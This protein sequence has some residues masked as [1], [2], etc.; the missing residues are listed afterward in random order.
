MWSKNYAQNFVDV[1][2]FQFRFIFHCNFDVFWY[3]DNDFFSSLVVPGMFFFFIVLCESKTMH[4]TIIDVIFFRHLTTIFLIAWLNSVIFFFFMNCVKQKC[5][6]FRRF[7]FF[8]SFNYFSVKYC[9]LIDTLDNGFFSRLA[10]PGIFVFLIVMVV[11][12]IKNMLRTPSVW[13]F[14][15]FNLF[16]NAILVIFDVIWYLD[17]GFFG[18]LAVPGI[19]FF[20][21]V[22]V[23]RK[24]MHRTSSIWFFF[25]FRII[26]H[27]NFDVFWYLDNDFFSSLAEPGIFLFFIV[28]VWSKNMHRTVR[29]D[30]FSIFDNDFFSSLVEPGIFFFFIVLCESKICTELRRC[31]LF[32]ISIYFSSQFWWL[33]IFD[34]DFLRFGWTWHLF[35]LY[36]IVWIKNLTTIFLQFWCSLVELGIF[37]FFIVIVW[38]KNCAQNFVDMIFFRYLTIFLEFI[39]HCKNF[40]SMFFFNFDLFFIAMMTI[41]DNDFLSSLA[42]PGIFLF[43]IVLCESK[44]C[45][46]LRRCF[47]FNFDLFFIAIL[48]SF[49]I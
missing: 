21:I 20:F 45:S 32:S 14:F 19:F 9:W 1:I 15:Y 31:D 7:E 3:L 40:S 37:F 42:E 2:F 28:I 48:M 22:I 10:E 13:F 36:R 8:F 11:K 49:D 46:E 27:C 23:W 6:E 41:F 38:S 39:F 44:T 30:L 4:R 33:L 34:N 43:F 18:S 16:L 12:Q 5:T 17:N 25:Q 47:F 35:V 24:K 26:F 29:C